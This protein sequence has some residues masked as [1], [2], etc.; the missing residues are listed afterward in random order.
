MFATRSFWLPFFPLP[1]LRSVLFRL[2]PIVAGDSTVLLRGEQARTNKA[3][4]IFS[5]VI[6]IVTRQCVE[7]PVFVE[8]MARC[9][10]HVLIFWGKGNHAAPTNQL[11]TTGTTGGLDACAHKCYAGGTKERVMGVLVSSCKVFGFPGRVIISCSLVQRGT[12]NEQANTKRNLCNALSC[13]H[14]AKLL[15]ELLV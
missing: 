14:V 3:S 12:W 8:K 11:D 15:H 2:L 10:Q 4:T 5:Q 9:I 6:V 13:G 7:S 1:C